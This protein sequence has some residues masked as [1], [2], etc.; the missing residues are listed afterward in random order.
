V[1][2]CLFIIFFSFLTICCFAQDTVSHRNRLS[3]SVTEHYYVLKSNR[4]IKQGPYL[5]WLKHKVLLVRGHYEN[6]QK[7][8]VWQFFDT[9][10]KLAEKYDYDKKAFTYEAPLYASADFSYLFDVPFKIGD[11]VTRPLKVGGIYFGFIPYLNLFQCPFDP[12]EVN[13]DTFEANIELLISPLGRL[14]DYRVRLTS[15]IYEYDHIFHMD[16]NLFSLE[17]RIFRPATL[18]GEPVMSRIIIKCYVSPFG[19]LDFY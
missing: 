16:I 13:T 10:G 2:S 1:R 18:N 5:V 17:D 7:N 8:G 12:E 15:A 19:K 14:A 9:E 11:R 6:G 4:E 3:D